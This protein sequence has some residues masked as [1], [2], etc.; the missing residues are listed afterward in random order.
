MLVVAALSNG[1]RCQDPLRANR[2]VKQEVII[3]GISAVVLLFGV[4]AVCMLS[5]NSQLPEHVFDEVKD[6]FDKEGAL[7]STLRKVQL[8]IGSA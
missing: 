4:F 8:G 6:E 7:K 2:D 3:A 1:L 5:Q